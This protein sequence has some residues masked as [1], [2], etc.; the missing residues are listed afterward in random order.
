M[1]IARFA[2]LLKNRQEHGSMALKHARQAQQEH[3][4]PEKVVLS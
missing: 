3:K 2:F 4:E 1:T